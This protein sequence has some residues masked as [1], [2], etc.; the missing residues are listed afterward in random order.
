YAVD[1]KLELS[2]KSFVALVMSNNPNVGIQ[3]L[4]L[5]LNEHS[6]LRA[7]GQF[8]PVATASFNTT[9]SLSSGTSVLD[10]GSTL[11]QLSQ[12]FNLGVTKPLK[13][14]TRYNISFSDFKTSS[15]NSF[16]TVNPKYSSNLNLSFSQPL[17]QGRGTA[18]TRIP[19]MVARSRL[20]GAQYNL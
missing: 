19:L 10:G 14:G 1:G 16:T 11:N 4:S 7:F 17:L 20:R 9:R 6:I 2:L 18:V 15:N 3:R 13:T 8:D 12:P 5:S